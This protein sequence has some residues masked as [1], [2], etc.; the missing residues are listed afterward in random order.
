MS[1]FDYRDALQHGVIHKLLMRPSLTPIR[2]L[3]T[4]DLADFFGMIDRSTQSFHHKDEEKGREWAPLSE[5]SRGKECFRGR[6]INQN[7]ET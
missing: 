5:A 7:R 3:E 4:F 2:E 6:A 1:F